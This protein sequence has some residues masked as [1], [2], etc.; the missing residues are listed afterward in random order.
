M[1][2]IAEKIKIMN[3]SK[4]SLITV[5]LVLVIG[6]EPPVVFTEIQPH[7][8]KPLNS[9]SVLYQ[10]A[11]R[12]ESDSSIVHINRNTVYKE[13][14]YPFTL[15]RFAIDTMPD[16]VLED[17]ELFIPSKQ[18]R[19]SATF[20]GDSIYS[21][22]ILRD[23]IFTIS[24]DQVL[25]RF[26]GHHILNFKMKENK[27]EIAILSLDD[28][29]NI[30]LSITALPEDLERLKEI[31]PVKDISRGDTIQYELSPTIYEFHQ[32]L[33]EELIFQSCDYYERVY[34]SII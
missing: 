28:N 34:P 30:I 14:E 4:L 25:T 11:Y 13:K 21:K 5:F 10:G 27:W 19:L 24:E 2:D 17:D 23:T 15:N 20:E 22:M 6:C 26:K 18:L 16:V 12:C 9:F 3:Y 7:G 32:I 1:N 29:A 31:T 33:K 8:F